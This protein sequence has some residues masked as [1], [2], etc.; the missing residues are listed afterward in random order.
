MASLI[1]MASSISLYTEVA[2]SQLEQAFVSLYR[3]VRALGLCYIF[4]L[5]S[6]VIDPNLYNS[7]FRVLNSE[8]EDLKLIALKELIE[9][10]S[11]LLFSERKTAEIVRQSINLSAEAVEELNAYET[12][13]TILD[14]ELNEELTEFQKR[15]LLYFTDPS[16]SEKDALTLKIEQRLEK[17]SP[18]YDLMRL[19]NERLVDHEREICDILGRLHKWM[20]IKDQEAFIAFKVFQF[21]KKHERNMVHFRSVASKISQMIILS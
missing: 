2:Y 3:R 8:K 7:R 13:T 18:L 10:R 5:K 15:I 17:T 19:E 4:G 16:D 21:Y 14:E 1:Q 12:V 6:R 11:Y 9:L 20:K